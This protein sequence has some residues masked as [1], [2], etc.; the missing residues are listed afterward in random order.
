MNGTWAAEQ[1][2]WVLT[3]CWFGVG[4]S[5]PV[6]VMLLHLINNLYKCACVMGGHRVKAIIKMRGAA[7]LW[8]SGMDGWLNRPWGVFSYQVMTPFL[9]RTNALLNQTQVNWTNSTFIAWWSGFMRHY[10]K[11]YQRLLWVFLF[12]YIIIILV[13]GYDPTVNTGK[14]FQHFPHRKS[15][16]NTEK[17]NDIQSQLNLK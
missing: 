17:N 3:S 15:N 1:R 4:S 5:V 9:K 7:N 6:W 16:N 8:K 12:F 11:A 10:C 13:L 14:L 2:I